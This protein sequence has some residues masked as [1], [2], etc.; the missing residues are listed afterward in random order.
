ML[1][2][3]WRNI[4]DLEETLNLDELQAILKA[5]RERE[6]REHKFMAALKGINL[7]EE[8]KES[9]QERFEKVQRRVAAK[10][11]GQSEAQLELD[12]LAFDFEQED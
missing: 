10:L 2:G 1:L 8:D 9:V 3:I 6:H 4:A 5:S 11:S 7:D 12:E